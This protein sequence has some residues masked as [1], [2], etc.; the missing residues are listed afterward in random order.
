V[1]LGLPTAAAFTH[2]NEGSR[3]HDALPDMP[4]DIEEVDRV[5]AR[6]SYTLRMPLMAYYVWTGPLWFRAIKLGCS[7]RTMMRR[8]RTAEDWIDRQFAMNG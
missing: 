3:A 6:M 2:A 1:Y 5:I 4:E 7:R 8:L